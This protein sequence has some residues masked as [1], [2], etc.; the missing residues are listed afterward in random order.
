MPFRPSARHLLLTAAQTAVAALMVQGAAHAATPDPFFQ[1]TDSAQLAAAAPGAVLKSR[2]ITAYLAGIKTSYQATQIVYRST[3]ALQRPAANVTTIFTPD[4]SKVS[5]AN[6]NKV[7]SYQSFYDS[8]NPEDAPSRA[9]AGG[10]RLPEV[11][12]AVEAV[13]FGSYV[14]NGYTVIISDTEGQKANFAAGPEY[15]YNTL[16]SIRAAFNSSQIGLSKSAKVVMMGYSGGAIA[17][18]WAA[19]LAP[20]YA[21]DLSDNL[22]GAA[23]GGT[24]VSPEHNLTYVEGAPI[25]GGVMPMAVLG[26]SRSYEIDIKKYLTP[27]GLEVFDRMQKAS[28]AYVLGQYSKVTWKDL[29][30]PEFQDRTKIPEYVMAVNKVIMG[31]GGTPAIPLQIGQGTGGTLELTKVSPIWGKGDGVMLA[32][33]VRTLARE[34]CAKGVPVQHKEWGSSHFLSI[35][36][37]LPWATAWVNDRFAGKAAPQNCSSIAVGNPLTPI[38]YNP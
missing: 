27:R 6:K 18:E 34:Y 19:E 21:P 1:Y 35:A 32:G 4:C 2:T 12:P 37:W 24:L 23:F 17:T 36:N 29:V 28:I 11:L 10:T 8:L 30:K 7:V 26:V 14:K 9:Y 5:C 22:I 33:D 16:D 38:V 25:W 31:T 15:G 20:S 13:L 3:D